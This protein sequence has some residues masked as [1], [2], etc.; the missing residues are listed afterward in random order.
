[1]T[2]THDALDLTV[3]SPSPPALWTLDIGPPG[4][5]PPTAT[6]IWWAPKHCGWQASGTHSSGMLSCCF[7]FFLELINTIQGYYLYLLSNFQV[8]TLLYSGILLLKH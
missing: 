4:P 5:S 8:D 2:I 1:M 6:D 7:C 3:R